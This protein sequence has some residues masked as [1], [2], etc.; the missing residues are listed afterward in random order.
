MRPQKGDVLQLL[1]VPPISNFLLRVPPPPGPAVA[2]H[3]PEAIIA[4]PQ[5]FCEK[6]A[7]P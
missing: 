2:D 3:W 5:L 1:R 4:E 6:V 7:V